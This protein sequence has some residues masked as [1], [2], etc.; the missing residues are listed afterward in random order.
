MN[1][2]LSRILIIDMAH[3]QAGP[4]CA[5]IVGFHDGTG[6]SGKDGR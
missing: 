6:S 2:V 1:K 3:N 5:Q 4:A